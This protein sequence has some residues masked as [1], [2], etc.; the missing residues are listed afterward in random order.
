MVLQTEIRKGIS[1]ITY[2]E[3]SENQK[4]KIDRTSKTE[5][6]RNN[7]HEQNVAN[8]N[9]WNIEHRESNAE[10]RTS[11]IYHRSSNGT[12][13]IED[14]KSN[15]E[16]RNSNMYKCIPH[17]FQWVPVRQARILVVVLY[18]IRNNGKKK[19]KLKRKRKRKLK[20]IQKSKKSKNYN[21]RVSTR[22]N[23]L[24]HDF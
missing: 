24:W 22:C 7:E 15:I 19:R 18:C 23:D 16:N 3:A 14:R 4:P 2:R 13:N 9:G 1:S 12:T 6:G 20:L 21:E 10:H 11:Q 5:N 8:R 17:G